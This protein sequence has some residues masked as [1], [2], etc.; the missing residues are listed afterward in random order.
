VL[1]G[2]QD[3]GPGG[4]FPPNFDPA[5]LQGQPWGTLTFTF[6][7]CNHGAVSWQSDIAGYGSGS[8]PIV[9]LTMPAGLSCP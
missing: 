2:F 3:V 4:R 6:S 8:M 1:Q 7:D 5:H 9:R